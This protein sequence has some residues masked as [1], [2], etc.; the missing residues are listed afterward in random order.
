MST[1]VPNTPVEKFVVVTRQTALEEL[2]ERFNTREQARFYIEHMGASFSEYEAAHDTY[3]ASLNALK[4]ALPDTVRQQFIERAFLPNFTF[5]PNDCVVT[6]GPDG[7]V[8]NTAKYLSG[9]P[10]I[11]FNPDPQR[12]DGVLLP[13]HIFNAPRVLASVVR[14]NYA[15]KKV[16]MAKAQLND[17]Q[18]L[19]AVNDFFIG[20]RTHVSARY[21]LRLQGAH[22]EVSEHQSSSGI[23]VS[24][25]AGSTGW[26][27]SILTGAAGVVQA[28]EDLSAQA[29]SAEPTSDMGRFDWE[30]DYLVFSVREPFPSKTSAARTVFGRIEGGDTLE[31]VSQMP[32]NGVIFSDGVEADYLEFNS[33]TIANVGLSEKK[34]HLVTYTY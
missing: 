27:R 31:V 20:Q 2:V 6:L 29:Q 25:G 18:V 11:A 24:T 23:I 32:Q 30:A 13:F 3:H 34:L 5:G 8:V 16:S 21:A 22:G 1:D 14:R 12:I 15:V 33:G 9:Q 4:A 26:L 10:L 19:H 17:G 28:Q 7:L